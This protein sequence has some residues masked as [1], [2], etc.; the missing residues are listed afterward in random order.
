MERIPRLSGTPEV[1]AGARLRVGA[2]DRTSARR[3]RTVSA[4]QKERTMRSSVERFAEF[5]QIACGPPEGSAMAGLLSQCDVR[6]CVVH[7]ANIG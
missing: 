6:D 1:P 7:V 3:G 4:G 5:R 2:W